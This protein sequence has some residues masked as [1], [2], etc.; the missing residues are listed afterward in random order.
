M[1]SQY[2]AV[3]TFPV[4]TAPDAYEDITLEYHVFLTDTGEVKL[5]LF[6]SPT[7]NYNENKGLRYAVSID[8]GEEHIV[9]F[10][11]QYTDREW[12]KWVANAIITSTTVHSVSR[13]GFHTIRYRVLDPGIVLQKLV[14]DC[15]GVK[16]SYL[17]PPESKNGYEEKISTN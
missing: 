2:D 15:G 7:L 10:N 8:D 4:K 1:V 16:P 9:N 14:L 5:T 17:G 13:P 12:E 6:F 3:T 11:H